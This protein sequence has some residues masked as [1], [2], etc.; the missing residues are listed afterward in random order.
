MS[1]VRISSLGLECHRDVRET[2]S[3]WPCLRVL[4]RH[5]ER[6]GEGESLR[7]RADGAKMSASSASRLLVR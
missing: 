2:G 3:T 6:E 5:L 1:H 7:G 4:V